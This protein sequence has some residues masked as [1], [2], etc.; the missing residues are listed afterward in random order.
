MVHGKVSPNQKVYMVNEQTGRGLQLI[1]PSYQKDEM[2]RALI[3]NSKK[4]T[5]KRRSIK[6]KAKKKTSQSKTKRRSVRTKKVGK[7]KR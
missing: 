7:R 2:N 3:T 1:S 4:V 5:R 6:S